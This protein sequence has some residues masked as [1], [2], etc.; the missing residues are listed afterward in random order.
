LVPKLQ[1]MQLDA[2]VIK[3][4]ITEKKEFQNNVSLHHNELTFAEYQN[5]LI[6]LKLQQLEDFLASPIK[7]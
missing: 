7:E 1:N 6:L 5:R 2:S 3:K 4:C